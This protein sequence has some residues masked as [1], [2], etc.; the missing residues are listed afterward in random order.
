[1]EL[2]GDSVRKVDAFFDRKR[3]RHR[4][5]RDHHVA[6]YE[7]STAREYRGDAREESRLASLGR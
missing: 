3:R 1:L 7:A 4:F 5:R 2:I 6:E